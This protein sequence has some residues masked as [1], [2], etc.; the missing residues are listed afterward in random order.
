METAKSANMYPIQ[1]DVDSLDWKNPTPSQIANR[2][3][4]QV[5][6]GS[7]I[8]FHNGALNT[9]TALPTVIKSLQEKGYQIV[10]VSQLIYKDNYTIDNA[11]MQIKNE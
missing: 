6:P 4:T 3:L 8:L 7:I 5:K 11:G 1:W 10:P 2:V 9:P